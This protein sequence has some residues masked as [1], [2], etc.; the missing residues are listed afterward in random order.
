MTTLFS[1]CGKTIEDN[2]MKIWEN[3]PE[4]VFFMVTKFEKNGISGNRD[5]KR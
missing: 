3:V 5:I 1:D 4:Y 2:L